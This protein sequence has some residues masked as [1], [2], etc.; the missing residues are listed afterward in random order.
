MSKVN[1]R[2]SPQERRDDKNMCYNCGCGLPNDDMGKGKIS[3]G[4][5][6]LTEDDLKHIA[7]EWGMSLEQ[8]KKNI[9]ELLKK[10]LG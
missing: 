8:T 10:E 6:S 2:L 7:K 3:R 9:F 4:G 5:G 1:L